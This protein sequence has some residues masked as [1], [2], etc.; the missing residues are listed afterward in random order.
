L[1][2]VV[3]AAAVIAVVFKAVGEVEVSSNVK[4]KF[5]IIMVVLPFGSDCQFFTGFTL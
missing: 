2:A 5:R 1:G 4:S 3:L